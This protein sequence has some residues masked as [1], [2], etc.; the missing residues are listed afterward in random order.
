[1]RAQKLDISLQFA[2]AAVLAVGYQMDR[3]IA[4]AF[5]GEHV[6]LVLISPASG[7]PANHL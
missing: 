1:M 5:D 6:A 2:V 7:H 3:A 4:L